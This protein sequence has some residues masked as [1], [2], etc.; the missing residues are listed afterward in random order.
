M[1][2]GPDPQAYAKKLDSAALPGVKSEQAAQVTQA[3]QTAQTSQASQR[4]KTARRS[5]VAAAGRKPSAPLQPTGIPVVSPAYPPEVEALPAFTVAPL[6]PLAQSPPPLQAPATQPLQ[7][8][9]TA[10]ASVPSL[11]LPTDGSHGNASFSYLPQAMPPFSFASGEAASL[12]GFAPM[13]QEGVGAVPFSSMPV[14]GSGAMPFSSMPVES[15]GAVPFS[16]MPVEGGGAMPLPVYSQSVS[17]M[18]PESMTRGL[19]GGFGFARTPSQSDGMPVCAR[20][21]GDV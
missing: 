1:R 17:W 19:S 11:Y 18:K 3:A 2:A 14:E 21:R 4:G 20:K 12:P 15:S 13:S 7:P 8:L 6:V 16:S 10:M 5:R 9:P